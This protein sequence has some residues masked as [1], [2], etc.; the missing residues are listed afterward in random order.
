M[1][2]KLLTAVLTVTSVVTV[3]AQEVARFD[4]LGIVPATLTSD[5]KPAPVGVEENEITIMDSD[6][7]VIKKFN[8]K[9]VT[10][11]SR[12]YS[13]TAAVKPSGAEITRTQF[14]GFVIDNEPVVA[15]NV[16]T[17]IQQLSAYYGYNDFYGFTDSKGRISCWSPSQTSC[18]RQEWLGAMY[19]L[20]YHC[21]VDGFV[22]K[23]YVEYKPVFDQSAIDNAEWTILED[24]LQTYTYT[25]IPDYFYY[26]D[27]DSNIGFDERMTVSQTLFNDDAK[28]EYL[29]PKL[30]P[31][32]K[33]VGDWWE[34][35][36]NENGVILRR[37]AHESQP[38]IGYD[39]INEDGEVVAS[40]E[41]K[42]FDNYIYKIG[43]NI[44]MKFYYDGDDVFYR[45]DPISTSIKEV[46]RSA[47]KKASVKV[48]G[49]SITVEADGKEVDEAVLFDMGGRRVATSGRR[50][51]GN[52]TLYAADT[53][54][55]VYNV[56][57]KKKGRIVGAQKIVLK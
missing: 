57:L 50:G 27:Y 28:W 30:G 16:N 22:K 11:E 52:I 45:Y 19:P 17:M 38:T 56:A 14:Y 13:E 39:I 53:T 24:D 21:I 1:K 2:E 29:F 48:N 20:A 54:H 3:S 18:Y 33:S 44:Y 34:Y 5:D 15:T 7:K 49:R 32:E 51:A 36:E 8:F 55:G 23:I 42:S 37:N 41:G 26:L 4:D 10:T 35:G 25:E 9:E 6:F 31:V 43:G 12:R 40:L 47:T 46:S